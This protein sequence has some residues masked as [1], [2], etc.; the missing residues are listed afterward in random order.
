[1]SQKAAHAV[2]LVA[3]RFCPCPAFLFSYEGLRS[4]LPSDQDNL[5]SQSISKK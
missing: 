5:L 3:D 2:L 1:M 4:T